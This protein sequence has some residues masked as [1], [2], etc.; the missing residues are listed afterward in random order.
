MKPWI[1]CL[2][3]LCCQL[4]AH[5]LILHFYLW[6]RGFQWCGW[7]I[8][9]HVLLGRVGMYGLKGDYA[10]SV[11]VTLILPANLVIITVIYYSLI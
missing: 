11:R 6:R 8:Q 4:F 5:Y 9:L 1:C 7:E 10:L 3:G 2:L